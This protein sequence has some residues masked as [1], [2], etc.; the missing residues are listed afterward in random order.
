MFRWRVRAKAGCRDDHP[1]KSSLSLFVGIHGTPAGRPRRGL[2]PPACL[3]PGPSLRPRLGPHSQWPLDLPTM[4]RGGDSIFTGASDRS[5]T[6]PVTS[7]LSEAT[8]AP[9]DARTLQMSHFAV[10]F[11]ARS[12]I[13]SIN[14]GGSTLPCNSSASLPGPPSGACEFRV[15]SG[16]KAACSACGRAGQPGAGGQLVPC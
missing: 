4:G 1:P 16:L 15:G 3:C 2:D 8:S 6:F 9:P 11:S 7:M 10:P 5:E 14:I 12:H 13:Y